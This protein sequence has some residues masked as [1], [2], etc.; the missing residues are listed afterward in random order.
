MNVSF[1]AWNPSDATDYWMENAGTEAT[2]TKTFTCPAAL[3]KTIGN[4]NIP[5]GWTI[6]EK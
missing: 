1:T 4:N 5:S 2:G 6:V 3:P